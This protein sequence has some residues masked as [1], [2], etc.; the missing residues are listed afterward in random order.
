MI[1]IVDGKKISIEI[2][3]LREAMMRAEELAEFTGTKP[4]IRLLNMVE[5]WLR[6]RIPKANLTTAWQVWWATA[7]H[8]NN[9]RKQHEQNAEIGHWLGIDATK[10]KSDERI[11][12]LQNI[13]R[14]KAQMRLNNGHYNP[15]D[16][17]TVYSLVL[18]ATG[19]EAQARKA[20]A[21]AAEAFVD[22]KIGA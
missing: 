1:F 8:L 17:K 13:P 11:G 15:V 14:I 12:L 5:L 6:S 7:E 4:T 9:L 3:V 19:D 16:Y 2:D 18:L 21:A 20:Q 22:S 10:L